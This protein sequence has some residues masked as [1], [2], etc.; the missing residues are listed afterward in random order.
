MSYRLTTTDQPRRR[1]WQRIFGTDQLPV[2]SDCPRVQAHA[3]GDILAYDLDLRA[4]TGPQRYRFAAWLSRRY[5]RSY[6]DTLRRLMTSASWPI[7]AAN[8]QIVALTLEHD[9][10]TAAG[11]SQG[12]RP[13]LLSSFRRFLRRFW[14]RPAAA[15]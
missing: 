2:L 11:D 10:E 4:L 15:G 12:A 8:C 3:Q 6:N 5:P 9:E 13:S 1:E 7:P 14:R